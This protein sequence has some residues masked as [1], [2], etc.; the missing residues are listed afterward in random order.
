MEDFIKCVIW[1]TPAKENYNDRGGR[2]II[3]SR[4]GGAYLI[5][6]SAEAVLGNYGDH[7]P[8]KV[9][10]TDWLVEQRRLGIRW[11]EITTKTIDDAK[12]W[13]K[14]SAPDRAD[15]ILRYLAKRSEMLGAEVGYCIFKGGEQLDE[16]HIVYLELLAHSGCVDKDELDYL[17]NYLY[18]CGLV[19][20]IT[21]TAVLRICTLTVGGHTRL[22]ELEKTFVASSEAFVAM[23]FDP[24]M[25][26]A[27]DNGFK[28]AIYDAGYVPVRI[29]K[30]EHVNK[31]DDE[32]IAGI[33]RARFVV[34]DFTHGT[35]GVR[36]SVY[37]EAGFA[38]GL[39]IPVI[40]TC[41][42]GFLKKIHFDTRQ[43]NHIKWTGPEDLR[44]ALKNR[45]LAVTGQGPN[46]H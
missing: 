46:K 9:R 41:Q 40:F 1:N 18:E 22:T 43:Y 23:W 31:I 45:I 28:P 2:E 6:G 25:D 12:Q 14:L 15:N 19:K 32:V 44:E 26:D 38:H 29:D 17:L 5:S 34:A 13:K 7:D 33:R 3:S 37:Y 20:F 11:P 4:A 30:R 24:S 42:K 27:W 10:L 39:N 36:G 21:K 8:I 16:L 35:K